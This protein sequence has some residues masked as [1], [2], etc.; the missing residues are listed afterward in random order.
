METHVHVLA[1]PKRTP[2]ELLAASFSQQSQN[3]FRLRCTWSVEPTGNCCHAEARGTTYCTT[4]PGCRASTSWAVIYGRI[5]KHF[6]K[7]HTNACKVSPPKSNMSLWWKTAPGNIWQRLEICSTVI[8]AVLNC[9]ELWLRVWWA[10]SIGFF[11]ALHRRV[12]QFTQ[13]ANEA[14]IKHPASLCPL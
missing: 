6:E 13:T 5:V 1:Q 11:T 14:I 10:A 2:A 4:S 7:F 9:S 12:K 8:P 3:K